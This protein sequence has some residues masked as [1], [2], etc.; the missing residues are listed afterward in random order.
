MEFFLLPIFFRLLSKQKMLDA[1]AYWRSESKQRKMKNSQK[2]QLR[3]L[4]YKYN[5]TFFAKQK[6]SLPVCDVVY[7]V[8]V[9][10]RSFESERIIADAQSQSSLE[11]TF[12]MPICLIFVQFSTF[13]IVKHSWVMGVGLQRKREVRLMA[14]PLA[15]QNYYYHIR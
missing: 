7:F 12:I 5:L 15:I 9:S 8:P 10:P 6:H 1:S 14:V 4:I 13:I 11:I 2:V 3:T